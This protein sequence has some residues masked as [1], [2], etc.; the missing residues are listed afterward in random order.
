MMESVVLKAARRAVIGKQVGAA[1]RAGQLPAVLYGRHIQPTPVFLNLRDATFALTR[2]SGSALV[3]I[4]LEG[5]LH[6]ALVR[7]KQRNYLT[8]SLLHV[9]FQVVSMTETLRTS[10][11]LELTGEAPA[12]KIYSGILVANLD[13]LEVECLPGDLPEVIKVDVSGLKEIGSALHVSDLKLP[14]GVVVLDDAEGIVA[15]ITAPANEE[16]DDAFA[17]AEPEVVQKGK[18]EEEE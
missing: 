15:V 16:A 12:V 13:S 5:E 3:T 4:D 1:R 11:A 7:E 10:V 9:D 2:L 8:G 14:A 17:P 18:K 6:R